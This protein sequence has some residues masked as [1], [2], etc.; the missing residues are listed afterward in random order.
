MKFKMDANKQISAKTN[1]LLKLKPDADVASVLKHLDVAEKH[2]QRGTSSDEE[3]AFTDVVYRCNQVFEGI[4]KELYE[5]VSGSPAEK[6]TP[7][8]IE[9]FLIK[10]K[11]FTSRI[12]N[13]LTTY[14]KEWRNTS[15]HDHKIDF[16]EQEAFVAIS[17]VSTFCYVAID[18]MIFCLNSSLVPEVADKIESDGIDNS[19]EDAGKFIV[20]GLK[21]TLTSFASQDGVIS[22]ESDQAMS[23]MMLGFI[24][25]LTEQR[26][27]KHEYKT[28]VFGRNVRIDFVSV[29][30]GSLA[31]YELKTYTDVGNKGNLIKAGTSFLRDVVS[32]EVALV[33]VLFVIPKTLH[34]SEVDSI[35]FDT[36]DESNNIIIVHSKN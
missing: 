2:F 30:D 7:A 36:D 3:D 14:R 22:F 31:A 35:G 21:S 32:S 12:I 16:N 13:Y 20:D 15:T 11:S 5:V 1:A 26:E 24:K 25:S 8:Q 9:N 33:G 28:E 6:K 10:E 23:G 4:V 34:V 17:N 19:L 18:H 29:H 27:V